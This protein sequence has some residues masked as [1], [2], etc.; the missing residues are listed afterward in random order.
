VLCGKGPNCSETGQPTR[1]IAERQNTS[2]PRLEYNEAALNMLKGEPDM[3]NQPFT[4]DKAQT[5]EEIQVTIDLLYIT[6]C[7]AT[8]SALLNRLRR[9]L[10]QLTTASQPYENIIPVDRSFE[11]PGSGAMQGMPMGAQQGMPMQAMPLSMPQQIPQ[12]MQE[13]IPPYIP[14]GSQQRMQM[15]PGS[16]MQQGYSTGQQGGLSTQPAPAQ[17]SKP[18]VQQPKPP[19]Q[20]PKPQTKDLKSFT[21]DELS[22][23]DGKGDNPAYVSVNGMVY[24][25][26]DQ[27]GWAAGSHFGL[28]SGLDQTGAYI[29]C[30]TG[31]PMIDKLK[32]IGRL[33]K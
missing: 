28:K 8:K 22:R 21:V 7:R 20:Q 23:F 9:L 17:Q 15:P 4:P 33:V 1:R 32:L 12:R 16:S 29:S 30:H 13:E 18:P 3:Y 24:D 11:L 19:A 6:Q 26:T 14:Q 25:V 10:A 27:P 2:L 31:Q 5:L